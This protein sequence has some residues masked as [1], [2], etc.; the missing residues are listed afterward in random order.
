MVFDPVCF[1]HSQAGPIEP[2]PVSA[3]LPSQVGSAGGAGRGP[4]VLT[5]LEE[6]IPEMGS[7]LGTVKESMGQGILRT[8]AE[9]CTAWCLELGGLSLPC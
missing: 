9:S 2:I 4:Q 5:D 8:G 7:L 3:L 1:S 6:E